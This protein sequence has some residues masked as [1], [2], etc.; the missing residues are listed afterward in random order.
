[1]RRR[2]GNA[3]H[4]FLTAVVALLLLSLATPAEAR[5]S[6]AAM[7]EKREAARQKR[8]KLAAELNHLRASDAQL[9]KAVKTLDQQVAAQ[10]A[11]ADAARQAVQAALAAVAESEARIKATETEMATMHNAVI[12][13]AVS[14]Y[15]RPKDN[16]IVGVIGAKDLGE[17]SRRS[18][19]LAQVTNK[20]RDVLDRL[21]ALRE[22]LGDEQAKAAAARDV[23]AER[24]EAVLARLSELQ[25]ARKEK[26]RLS[27]AL[28]ARIRQYQA[29]ADAV[30]AQ[31]SGLTA[32]IQTRTQARASRSA[33]DPGLDGRIS[34]AGLVWPLRGT[35]TSPFG[36]RWG[37][38]HAGLD[39]SGGTGTPI[40]AAKGGQVIFAGS[41]SGYG[42]CVIID[43][44]GGLTTLYA[45]QSRLGT[46]DGAD[47]GQ[48]DVIGY[49]GST[50]HSTGPHLHFETRVGGSPQNPRRYL[51]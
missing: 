49:V 9:T 43:H 17:A 38:L 31:E 26:Q 3:A 1:M 35:V 42:N 12:N 50:G 39:I 6:V 30:A 47:V 29:E 25:K 34:G 16:A 32:L 8:A 51:P 33:A 21:R 48:G 2:H 24:R 20:D 44:G 5:E 27:A 14:V 22:D 36:P 15:V 11:G 4:A 19:L 10:Q 18:S 46:S 41:M 28:D 7:R 40:R 23:A 45:H 13:R 37:R